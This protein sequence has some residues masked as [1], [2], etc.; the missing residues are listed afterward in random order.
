MRFS[1]IPRNYKFYDL[2][3]ESASNLVVAGEALADLFEHFENLEMK[4]GQLKELEHTGDNITHDLYTLSHQTFVTP[5][6][7]EDIA[8]LTQQM[9]D[10]MDHMEE[11]AALTLIYGIEEPTEAARGLADIVRLQCLQIERAVSTLRRQRQLNKIH[12]QLREINRLENEG[13]SLLRNAMGEMFRG[14]MAMVEIIKWREIYEH[15]EAATDSAEHVSHV[16]E[17]ITLKHA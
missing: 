5:L 9:D 10:V 7:R 8:A 14:E 11:A 16:L 17:A 13:D 2:F 3:E 15:L 12:E 4:T 1:L 6:D